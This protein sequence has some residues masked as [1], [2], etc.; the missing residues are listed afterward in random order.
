ME[1]TVVN[2][3]PVNRVIQSLEQPGEAPLTLE[4][5]VHVLETAKQLLQ[6]K[7]AMAQESSFIT[8]LMEFADQ[9]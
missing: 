4:Q 3:T 7:E 5:C 9:A 6:Y 8:S 2:L 1:K